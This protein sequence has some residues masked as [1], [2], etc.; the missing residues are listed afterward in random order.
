M[1]N[2]RC[3]IASRESKTK[4]WELLTL[5]ADQETA[6]ASCEAILK[7]EKQLGNHKFEA[8]V[9]LEEDFD[10]GRFRKRVSRP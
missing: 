7:Q 10:A 6:W 5:C 9:L 1:A 2:K 4:E 3:V 8:I